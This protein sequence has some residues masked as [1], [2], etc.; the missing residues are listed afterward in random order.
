[1]LL[2]AVILARAVDAMT[3]WGWIETW[4]L[5]SWIIKISE[6][7]LIIVHRLH[8]FQ[9]HTQHMIVNTGSLRHT[10]KETLS[11]SVPLSLKW[12][13]HKQLKDDVGMSP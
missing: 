12:E 6:P 5:H 4:F 13:K 10:G 11:G 1:M 2:K 7:S 3:G 8:I 9:L